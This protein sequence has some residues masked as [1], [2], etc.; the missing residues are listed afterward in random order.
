M[1]PI[2]P[3]TYP[4]PEAKGSA[5]LDLVE[6]ITRHAK[7]KAKWDAENSETTHIVEEMMWLEPDLPPWLAAFESLNCHPL[8]SADRIMAEGLI[9]EIAEAWQAEKLYY[10]KKAATIALMDF[11][12]GHCAQL[13][14]LYPENHSNYDQ[15]IRNWL[16]LFRDLGQPVCTIDAGPGMTGMNVYGPYGQAGDHP[17]NGNNKVDVIIDKNRAE[18]M[19]EFWKCTFSDYREERLNSLAAV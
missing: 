19:L 16:Q 13:I 8:S 15:R 9:K 18:E 6:A 2:N 12:V 1:P 14:L 11:M 17:V 3:N 7:E 10:S 4:Y 5:T